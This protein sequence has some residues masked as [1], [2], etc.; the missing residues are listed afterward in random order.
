MRNCN[1]NYSSKLLTKTNPAG[2]TRGTEKI[3]TIVKPED[4]STSK[5]VTTLYIDHFNC[6]CV[7]VCMC[8]YVCVCVCVY[9]CV[10]VCVCVCVC[11]ILM[12][13]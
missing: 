3:P 12:M 7:C 13:S 8:V 2:T 10:R 6:V 9:V 4:V 1:H 11:V 5:A